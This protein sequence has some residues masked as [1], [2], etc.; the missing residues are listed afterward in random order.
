MTI[1]YD[2]LVSPP[3]PP[4]T[5]RASAR[6]PPPGPP[7]RLPPPP[8][9]RPCAP[10]H[11]RPCRPPPASSSSSLRFTRLH[12]GALYEDRTWKRRVYSTP[13]FLI[14]FWIHAYMKWFIISWGDSCCRYR[15]SMEKKI[16]HIYNE[17]AIRIIAIWY[18]M[19]T[20]VKVTSQQWKWLQLYKH[21]P[22]L[23]I[24]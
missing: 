16:L 21:A 3:M 4:P 6:L 20:P 13:H 10:P 11:D 1:L 12:L 14:L 9:S 23:L 18:D 17:Q 8:P 19:H 24:G 22:I 15:F 7:R 2:E 5:A